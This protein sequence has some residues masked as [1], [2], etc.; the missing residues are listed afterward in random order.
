MCFFACSG[1]LGVAVRLRLPR[2]VAHEQ[3][4]MLVVVTLCCCFCSSAAPVAALCV[5]SCVLCVLCLV[6]G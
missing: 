2:A 5:L 4:V 3:C 6:W 1:G